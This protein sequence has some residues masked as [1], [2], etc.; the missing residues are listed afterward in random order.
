SRRDH[1]VEVGD[2]LLE[3]PL[4]RPHLLG[5]ELARV[6]AFRLRTGDAE[7]EPAGAKALDLL[8]DDRPYVEARDDRSEPARGRDRLQAGDDAARGDSLDARRIGER[9]EEADQ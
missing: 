2:P 4:L 5:G 3:R 8:A 9:I 7:V 6:A 1:C